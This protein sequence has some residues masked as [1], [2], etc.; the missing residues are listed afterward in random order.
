MS[1]EQNKEGILYV[2]VRLN[3]AA[4]EW[5]KIRESVL[6]PIPRIVDSIGNLSNFFVQDFKNTVDFISS[7]YKI[8]LK[9]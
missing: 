1:M 5:K 8:Y 9:T 3:R 2:S 4:T 7:N 6:K